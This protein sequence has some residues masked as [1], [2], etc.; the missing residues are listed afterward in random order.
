MMK[1]E[2]DKKDIVLALPYL[3]L[4]LGH[5]DMTKT[6]KYLRLVADCYPE[7]IEKQSEYLGETIP[8]LEGAE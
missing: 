6:Q 3:S 7:V 2:K 1:F 5:C 4:Y 8:V